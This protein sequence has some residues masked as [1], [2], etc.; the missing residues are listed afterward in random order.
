MRSIRAQKIKVFSKDQALSDPSLEIFDQHNVAERQI[1][2][3]EEDPMAIRRYSQPPRADHEPCPEPRQL[4]S[5]VSRQVQVFDRRRFSGG[6]EI[7]S[8]LD[9]LPVAAER[10]L[11]TRDQ[12][13]F[14]TRCQATPDTRNRAPFS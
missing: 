12:D 3:G 1:L 14:A 13:R 8:I 5:T 7:N 4:L 6:T 2:P 10:R 11:C 9:E